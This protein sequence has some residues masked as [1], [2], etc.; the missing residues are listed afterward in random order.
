MW[1]D[2]TKYKHYQLIEELFDIANMDKDSYMA[3]GRTIHETARLNELRKLGM[4]EHRADKWFILPVLR[5]GEVTEYANELPNVLEKVRQIPG[6]VNCTMNIYV[7]GGEA[8]IHSDYKYDM[9]EDIVDS[10]KCFAILLC[11]HVPSTDIEQCGFELGGIQIS[12]KSGDIIAFDGAIPHRSWNF[13]D[14][15]RFT[16][17]IDI[18]QD[19]WD[20]A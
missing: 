18:E 16:V 4:K 13:T 1:M 11:L 17:N 10:K 12:H 15:Y 2:Y 19:Y 14:D 5:N 8:P 9:R 6:V 3:T 20:K 7:P